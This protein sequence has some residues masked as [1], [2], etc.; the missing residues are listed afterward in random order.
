MNLEGKLLGNRYEIIKKIGNGG[1]AT[2]YKA[3]DKI[4]KRPVAIKILRDEFTTD[5]EFI[6]RFEAEAQSAA[7][8]THANIVSIYDVGVEGNL[9]FIV[10][11]LIQGKT[12]KEIIL[13]EQGP[14]PWKWSINVAI[15]IAQALEM[16]H[17]NNIIHRDIK[18]HNIIITEDGVAK[19]TDF[20]IAK[21]VSNSTI[22]AF[23]TTIGSVHY[24]SPEHAR[25]GFT[26][27]KSDL[28]S[29]GVVM[30]EMLTGRVPFDA[31]TPVSVAL[32]HMQEEPVEPIEL[33]PN[34]P[35]AINKIIM[36]ALKKDAT[37]RYQTSTEMLVDL[38]AALKNPDGDFVE[39]KEYDKTARTQKIDI[40]ELEENRSTRS[41][42][43]ENKFI[44]FVKKN[45]VICA[46]V[47][48]VILFFLA[49]GGT[50]AFLGATNPKEATVP[51]VIGLTG[52]EAKQ[53]IEGAKLVYEV[54]NEEY[55]KDVEAG[56]V[57]S[58]RTEIGDQM[59]AIGDI[60]VKE[61]SKIFVVISKG[62]EKAKVPNVKGKEKDEAIKLLEE[63]KLKAEI[64]EENSKTVKE[65]CVISQET[66]ENTEVFAGDTVKIHV[67]IGAE[68]VT[69]V[70]VIDKNEEEAKKALKAIGITNINIAYE[71][72]SSKTPGKVIKQSI[73][74][75]SSV[76][77]DSSITITVNSYV[78]IK[79]VGLVINVKSLTGGYTESK[80][81]P[82][83]NTSSKDSNSTN[84]TNSSGNETSS[85]TS[86][87]NKSTNN[88]TTTPVE[89]TVNVSV[90]V[91]GRVVETRQNV[92]KNTTDLKIN[93]TGTGSKTITVDAGGS[94]ST[95]TVDLSSASSVN[96]P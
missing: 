79:T 66:E 42:N 95:K 94:K 80:S 37:L 9:Y 55:N 24:F 58:L 90:S 7:R 33:N 65:N 48:V 15:Q 13:E 26:D 92:D 27:A 8:L 85:N 40:S 35:T 44:A 71:E 77:K 51:N 2:V 4:L 57:I 61:G 73:E 59:K 3:T 1:M 52:D 23:G 39:Q 25:G 93:V 21:A 75:G 91:D 5:N 89:K 81:E 84:K 64:V 46:I 19:V 72:N 74:G 22:T 41:K 28:Y 18:P 14:L 47:G 31:D 54:E 6:R 69:M 38:K 49:F 68:K 30:Y 76:E 10:M 96:V 87:Q 53:K 56:K 12:L 67:S 63:A 82:E 62:Q 50:M 36:K 29:L 86:T 60:K 70:S 83:Q 34:L 16:A 20:G 78:E 32:K 11:E 88:S 43:N 17:R 45:K